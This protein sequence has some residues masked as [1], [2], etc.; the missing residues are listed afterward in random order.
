MFNPSYFD[1]WYGVSKKFEM[2][3]PAI[4][5]TTKWDIKRDG[6]PSTLVMHFMIDNRIEND[7]YARLKEKNLKT[8]VLQGKSSD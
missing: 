3:D 7:T 2:Y 5:P 8:V 6:K 4:R 1:G